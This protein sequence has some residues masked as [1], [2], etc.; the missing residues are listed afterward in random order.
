M[1]NYLKALLIFIILALSTS[2]LSAQEFK[3]INGR[4]ISEEFEL[5]PKATIYDMDTSI[6]GSTDKEGFFQIEI[7]IETDRLL[8]GYIGMEWMSIKIQDDCQNYEMIIMSDVIYDFMSM[9]KLKKKRKKR[10]MQL[11]KKHKEAFERGIFKS[12]DPCVCYI[13]SE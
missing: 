6:L 5:L 1:I 4:I 9:E 12:S 7:P 3:I 8:L 2:V 11:P 10:F 13:F